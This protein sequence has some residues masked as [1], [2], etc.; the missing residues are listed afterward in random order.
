MFHQNAKTSQYGWNSSPIDDTDIPRCVAAIGREFR[1]PL[2]VELLDKPSLNDKGNS[3]LLHYL[4]SVSG[5]TKFAMSVLQILLEERQTAYRERHNK[6]KS[7]IKFDLGD[8]VQSP[9]SSA[10]KHGYR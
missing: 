10:I 6:D 1:F 7:T 8:V 4:R 3:A 5:N 2:D 9:C